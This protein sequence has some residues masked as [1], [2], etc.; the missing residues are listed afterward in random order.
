DDGLAIADLDSEVDAPD[1]AADLAIWSR[2]AGGARA[3]VAGLPLRDYPEIDL[4]VPERYGVRPLRTLRFAV[5][6]RWLGAMFAS[7]E[8][9]AF[10]GATL[11]TLRLPPDEGGTAT[12]RV[13]VSHTRN[14]MVR[15]A[16][17]FDAPPRSFAAGSQA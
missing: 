3:M 1:A 2:E 16:I 17:V 15:E 8:V 12:Y 11:E 10:D 13:R 6:G 9:Q 5:R 14:S 4:A 7:R